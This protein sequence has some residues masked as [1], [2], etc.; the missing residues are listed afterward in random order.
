MKKKNKVNYK[1]RQHIKKQRHHFANKCP[2]SRSYS[3]SSNVWMWELDCKES[4][5]PK[6][7][8]FWTVVLE[9]TLE[10]HL[11]SEGIKP[12]NPKGNQP[13]IFIGR[14]DA[15]AE[16]PILWPPDTK[17]WLTGKDPDAGINW[18]Q[19]E[20]VMTEDEMVGWH[21]WLNGYEFEHTPGDGE[22]Q[23]SLACCI[24][25]SHRESYMTENWTTKSQKLPRWVSG[26]EPASLLLVQCFSD[27]TPILYP[28]LQQEMVGLKYEK[29][30]VQHHKMNPWLKN[31]LEVKTCEQF[32]RS[33]SN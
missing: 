3:F 21:H 29:I 30:K 13:W 5:T 17:S 26:P 18:G 27:Y 6:N 7:W 32:W 1:P 10:N 2:Y 9:K 22:G 31:K 28:K 23:G 4:W 11:D 12:I 33:Q 14:T 15:E 16:A 19:E 8:C 24:P 25:W 20:Q